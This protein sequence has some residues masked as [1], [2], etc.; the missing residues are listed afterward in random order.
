VAAFA[1]SRR[2][3]CLI[4]L[5]RIFQYFIAAVRQSLLPFRTICA[6]Q[7]AMS[8]SCSKDGSGQFLS[9]R[10]GKQPSSVLIKNM[11]EIL[12]HVEAS[13]LKSSPVSVLV[14]QEHM[15][16]SVSLLSDADGIDAS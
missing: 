9:D 8:N 2:A 11:N 12:L 4:R 3:G 5:K 1:A 14:L 13:I 6:L 16:P 15:L 7:K 10:A